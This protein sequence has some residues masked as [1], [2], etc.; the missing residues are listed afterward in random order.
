MHEAHR[1]TGRMPAKVFVFPKHT[2]LRRKRTVHRD[3]LAHVSLATE[4]IEIPEIN[5]FRDQTFGTNRARDLANFAQFTRK[6]G[7]GKLLPHLIELLCV[8]HQ[9]VGGI[10]S[11]FEFWRLQIFVPFLVVTIPLREMLRHALGVL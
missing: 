2:G 5:I 8:E 1:E 3:H 10:E 7:I 11:R 9:S 4:S 6:F